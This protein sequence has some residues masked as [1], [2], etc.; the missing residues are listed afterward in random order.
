VAL[1]AVSVD[2]DCLLQPAT[3]NTASAAA[4]VAIALR[5]VLLLI[6]YLRIVCPVGD[7]PTARMA[8]ELA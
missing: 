7:D 4:L 3:P 1:E 2:V 6:C 5:T 8:S